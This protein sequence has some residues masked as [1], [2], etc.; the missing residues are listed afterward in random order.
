MIEKNV[1][2]CNSGVSKHVYN[3]VIGDLSWIYALEPESKQQRTVGVLK[4]VP[5]PTKKVRARSNTKLMVLFFSCCNY[6]PR[7]VPLTWH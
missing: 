6:P 4:D 7:T 2:K 1:K 5:N 3:I